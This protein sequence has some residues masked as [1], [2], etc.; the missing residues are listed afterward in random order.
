MVKPKKKRKGD[1]AQVA[2]SVVQDAIRL[3]ERPIKAPKK[4]HGSKTGKN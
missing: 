4:P 2:Y 3:T 1:S